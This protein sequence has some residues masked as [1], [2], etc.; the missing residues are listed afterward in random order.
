MNENAEAPEPTGG[1]RS[2][3][4]AGGI[5]AIV[6]VIVAAATL[7][8]AAG[9]EDASYP[10]DSP[11]AAFQGYARAWDAG[12]TEGAWDMLTTTAQGRVSKFEFRDA[13]SWRG[14]EQQR[15]WIH[16][17]SGTDERVVLHVT[18]ET[19]G[20]GLL[21]GSGDWEETARVTMVREDGDWK[22]DT[23]LVGYY[24]W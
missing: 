7:V 15:L 14:E 2:T 13:N 23:P 3:W 20:G 17:R 10:P 9:R 22:I 11:E 24:R 16:D 18:I 1:G 19:T 5:V 8:L 21:F 6:L 4:L 12:D